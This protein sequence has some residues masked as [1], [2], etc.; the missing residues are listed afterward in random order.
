[1]LWL[2]GFLVGR[3]FQGFFTSAVDKRFFALSDIATIKHPCV[4]HFYSSNA[5]EQFTNLQ[6]LPSD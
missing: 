2:S 5:I 1:M 4:A 6:L 3:L